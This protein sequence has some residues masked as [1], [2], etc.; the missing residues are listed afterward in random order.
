MKEKVIAKQVEEAKKLD[1]KRRHLIEDLRYALKRVEPPLSLDAS[2]EDVSRSSLSILFLRLILELTLSFLP[3]FPGTSPNQRPRSR[4]QRR[5]GSKI[6][7]FE[8]HQET[9]GG[10]FSHLPPSSV[11]KLNRPSRPLSVLQEKLQDASP[12]RR[13]G[14]GSDSRRDKEG[15]IVMDYGGAGSRSRVD[16]D[17]RDR[18]RKSSRK[19]RGMDEDRNST[20]KVRSLFFSFS[21]VRFSSSRNLTPFFF[22]ACSVEAKSHRSSGH[23][24]GRDLSLI[25]TE[26]LFDVGVSC[27]G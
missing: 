20:S 15:D 27:A 10:T 18:E 23:R 25:S 9:E 21:L 1:R 6:R 11:S 12:D 5:R 17:R 16:E 22:S 8:V 13:G 7:V 24:G 19:D 26:S 3:F 4:A 2:Y 14:R